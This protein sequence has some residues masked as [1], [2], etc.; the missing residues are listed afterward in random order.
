[1]VS[2]V[3]G[4]II[5]DPEP[6][7]LYRQHGA[8]AVGANASAWQRA[9]R[10]LA[11][12]AEPFVRQLGDHLRVLADDGGLIPEN[13]ATVRML[14]GLGAAG[15]W[16]RWVTLARAGVYRQSFL[17]DALMYLWIALVRVGNPF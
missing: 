13:A 15:V 2:G 3:G 11:R 16:V 17:E 8:N 12:G 6:A 5:F 1:M 10:A 9:G 4:R 14:A 7:I